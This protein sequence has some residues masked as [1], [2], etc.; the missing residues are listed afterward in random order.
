[1]RL[2]GMSHL[3]SGK[4]EIFDPICFQF[5]HCSCCQPYFI[6]ILCCQPYFIPILGSYFIPIFFLKINIFE[7]FRDSNSFF[8]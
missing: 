7:H 2:I 5:H 8:S 1:M 6:P 3:P 4:S